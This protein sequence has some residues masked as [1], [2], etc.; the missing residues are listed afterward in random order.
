MSKKQALVLLRQQ[1]ERIKELKDEGAFP[2]K[3]KIWNN[4]VMKI[5]PLIFD[6]GEIKLY[7]DICVT[8]ISY[9]EAD[10][11]VQYLEVLAK[12]EKM[13]EG[14]VAEHERFVVE[15]TISLPSIQ[16][17]RVVPEKKEFTARVILKNIIEGAQKK[18][19]I[20]D[21][22]FSGD[23]AFTLLLELSNNVEIQI[24]IS[25]KEAKKEVFRVSFDKF[26]RQWRGSIEV[27]VTKDIHARNIIVDEKEAYVSDH[28]L[29]DA[30]KALTSIYKHVDKTSKEA[31]INH[32]MEKWN[33]GNPLKDLTSG[34][35]SITV[36][37][38][39]K[40]QI[41]ESLINQGLA[42]WNKKGECRTFLLREFDYYRDKGLT[43]EEF[44][45][46][47]ETIALRKKDQKPK[48]KLFIKG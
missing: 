5:L 44:E 41:R 42:I 45:E 2:P 39:N 26:R 10:R 11:Y 31:I 4:T 3:Y 29:K 34:A 7:R 36:L 38:K 30:G 37:E 6:E 25:P 27:R 43:E 14:L 1:I 47:Y 19:Q 9:D 8:R 35:K 20:I 12:K 13:L 32:F 21:P 22:Y 23:A 17:N 24:I 33:L 46:I 18:L 48:T 28:S 40:Y 16:K 15:E